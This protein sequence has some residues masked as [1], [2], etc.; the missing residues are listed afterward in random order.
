MGAS[1]PK[2]KLLI[3]GEFVESKTTQWRDVVNPA[4]QEVLARVPFA[5]QDEMNA[6]VAAAQDAF[7]TWRKTPIGAR[8]RIFLKYQQLIRENIKELAALLTAEQ[9]KTLPD[10]EG[11]VFRG[12]EVVEHAANIGT[13]QMGE[14]ANNVANG[15]DTYTLLQPIGVCAGITPFNFPAMIPL[16]MFPMAIACGNTFVLKPSEQDPL[17]TMRL[18]ELAL[19]AGIPK[20]VLNVIHG[21]VDAV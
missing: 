5:T 11:D 12:L 13:L 20:G 14:L 4:T 10:A 8:A 3:N 18:V 9:G 6:A 16:W 7:K 1:T 19:E 21:G 2:V 17:V 15:V